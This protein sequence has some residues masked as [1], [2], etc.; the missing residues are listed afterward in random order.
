MVNAHLLLLCVC[1]CVPM[2]VGVLVFSTYVCELVTLRCDDGTIVRRLEIVLHS[3]PKSNKR[4]VAPAPQGC[5]SPRQI[6]NRQQ[7]GSKAPTCLSCA[8]ETQEDTE[9]CTP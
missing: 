3:A 1:V 8:K 7:V 4:Q 2:C 5:S 9:H 6:D